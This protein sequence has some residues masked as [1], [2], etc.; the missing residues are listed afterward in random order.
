MRSARALK[1]YVVAAATAALDQA[2][3]LTARALLTPEKS[4]A[5]IPGFFDLDLV[6]NRGAAFGI[7]PDWSP[8]LVILGLC[9]VYAFFRLGKNGI[10]QSS[11]RLIFA[12]GLLAGGAIGNLIDR[13]VSREQAVIDFIRLHVTLDGRTYSWPNFNVADI[14]IVAGA[15][16]L[17][18]NV[19]AFENA[20]N[21]K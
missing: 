1:L 3:K 7:L 10:T 18:L 21:A 11:R 14:G 20:R 19:Y 5:I 13:F 2:T 4:V 9:A 8:L 15:A 12:L 6:Y 16:L 17:I